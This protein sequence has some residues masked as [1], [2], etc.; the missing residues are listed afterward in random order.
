MSVSV[1]TKDKKNKRK[2]LDM[3]AKSLTNLNNLQDDSLSVVDQQPGNT[4]T[5]L[6]LSFSFIGRR[7]SFTSE[8][9]LVGGGG[10]T[11]D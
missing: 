9:Y 7:Q 10:W 1:R 2:N 5:V 4:I 6:C 8:R 11:K 3:G